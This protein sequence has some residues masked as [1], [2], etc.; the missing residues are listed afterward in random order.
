MKAVRMAPGDVV[1]FML[2]DDTVINVLKISVATGPDAVPKMIL[3][4]GL[5]MIETINRLAIAALGQAVRRPKMA[6][7]FGGVRKVAH[8]YL[9]DVPVSCRFDP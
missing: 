3:H 9:R 6:G 5:D 2:G 4:G 7:V 8:G 1:K